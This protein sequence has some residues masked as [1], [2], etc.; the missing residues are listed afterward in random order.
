MFVC[1][2]MPPSTL[3]LTCPCPS[4]ALQENKGVQ[5]FVGRAT[6]RVSAAFS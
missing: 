6:K 3:L 1:S 2:P 5:D 4:P